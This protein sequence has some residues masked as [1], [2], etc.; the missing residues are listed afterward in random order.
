MSVRE[1]QALVFVCDVPGC[2]V[3]SEQVD[4]PDYDD[5]RRSIV[6]QSWGILTLPHAEHHYCPAHLPRLNVGGEP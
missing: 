2:R 1:F 4:L 3:E 5:V 6:L